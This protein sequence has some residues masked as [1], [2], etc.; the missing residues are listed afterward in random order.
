MPV[1]LADACWTGLTVMLIL[2]SLLVGMLPRQGE[3]R[4]PT[5]ELLLRVLLIEVERGG[6]D[7]VSLSGRGWTIAEKVSEMRTTM[8]TNHLVADHSM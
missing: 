2:G 6:V 3:S 8:F 1:Q 4:S 7:A 5:S